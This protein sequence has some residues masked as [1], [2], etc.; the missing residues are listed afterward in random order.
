MIKL[1]PTHSTVKVTFAVPDEGT[2]ISVVGDFNNWDPLVHPLKKRTNGTR[3]AA[4]VFVAGTSVRFRYLA[5]GGHFFDD[6][7]GVIEENGQG[8]THTMLN[9]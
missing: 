7:D 9:L 5:D 8:G 2:P 6:T 3:S 1:Q 4:V